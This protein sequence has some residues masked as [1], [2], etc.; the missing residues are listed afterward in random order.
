MTNPVTP[1]LEKP[2]KVHGDVMGGQAMTNEEGQAY[3]LET[4]PRPRR[5]LL[6]IGEC[7]YCDVNR[8]EPM[9]PSH[10]ASIRCES[11]QSFHCTCDTC[12]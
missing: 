1:V 11:G 8:N 6:K 7:R 9:M 2:V 3:Y 4:M 10:D 12:F 5:R